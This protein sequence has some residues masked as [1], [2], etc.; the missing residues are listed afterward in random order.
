M[1]S[2]SVTFSNPSPELAR[3]PCSWTGTE[4]TGYPGTENTDLSGYDDLG[5]F[6]EEKGRGK[7]VSIAA[8]WKRDV[9]VL[10]LEFRESVRVT[11]L[12]GEIA[13]LKERVAAVEA[14]KPLIVPVESLAPEPYEVIRPFHVILQP[15][16]D[17]YLATFF[18]A[19]IS[20]TGGTQR[21][22][23]E[24]LKDLVVTAF[25]MLT[26]HKQSELGPGPLHQINVL[27]QFIRRVE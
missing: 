27:K 12:E 6:V 7:P 21:E 15:A 11:I 13:S 16:G 22:A 3:H 5:C 17:E 24:N 20:A 10:L 2:R 18:D 26:R 23:V 14:Q 1:R 19:S 8:N 9:P 25:N 4:M